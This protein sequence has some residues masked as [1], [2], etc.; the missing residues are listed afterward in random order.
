[1]Y[2]EEWVSSQFS[3][4]SGL[5]PPISNPGADTFEGDFSESLPLLE[6][7]VLG[8]VA[9]DVAPPY[10]TALAGID[11]MYLSPGFPWWDGPS[12]AGRFSKVVP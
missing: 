9:M 7:D 10:L 8:C 5:F 4:C 12:S 6:V 1:L 2:G 3:G 11:S